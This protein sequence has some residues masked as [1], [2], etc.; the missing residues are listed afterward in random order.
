MHEVFRRLSA[1]LLEEA[2]FFFCIE[3]FKMIE[4]EEYVLTLVTYLIDCHIKE[5]PNL[6]F[7]TNSSLM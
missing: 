6:L 3:G 7:A 5:V 2:L 1:N 4:V